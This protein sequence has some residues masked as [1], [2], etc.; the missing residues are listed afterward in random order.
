M[1]YGYDVSPY[2]RGLDCCP[3]D[4]FIADTASDMI[5]AGLS[6]Y[7]GIVFLV[8]I[9]ISILQIIGM[10]KMFTKA[11]E[12]G[13]KSIIPIYN[14]VILFKISGL[15]PWLIL[16][17]FATVIPFVGWIVTFCLT[18]Y[19][20]YKL[21]KSFGKDIGYTIGLILVTPIFYMILGLGNAEYVGPGGEK[22]ATATSEQPI[23]EIEK[24]EESK[25]DEE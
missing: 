5:L 1:N 3:Y 24:V 13:W 2:A 16:A 18:I 19:Q 15:S 7:F 4:A 14:V 22:V 8:A 17:Y 20:S 25:S 9:V 10:W 21:S 23:A 12:K 6:I 11:G